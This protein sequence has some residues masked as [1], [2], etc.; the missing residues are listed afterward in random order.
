[1]V[2][3][4]GHDDQTTNEHFAWLHFS[5]FWLGTALHWAWNTDQRFLDFICFLVC[6]HQQ[7]LLNQIEP[8]ACNNLVLMMVSSPCQATLAKPVIVDNKW[9][10]SFIHNKCTETAKLPLETN[11]YSREE[12]KQK[13]RRIKQCLGVC[14]IA[15]SRTTPKR[16]AFSTTTANTEK[17]TET[18]DRHNLVK[19]RKKKS[20]VDV[21]LVKLS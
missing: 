6:Q 14:N 4:L 1:M 10:Y 18:T 5:H 12:R 21:A 17:M 8:T 3:R 7:H 2:R 11:H 19:V 13:A 20:C 16:P 9:Y 15:K